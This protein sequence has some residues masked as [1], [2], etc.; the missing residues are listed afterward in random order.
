M[1]LFLSPASAAAAVCR[2]RT[3]LPTPTSA[4]LLT[5][6]LWQHEPYFP[7]LQTSMG[8]RQ[9]PQRPAAWTHLRTHNNLQESNRYN[10]TDHQL[11]LIISGMQ[12]LTVCGC[13][14]Q[15][16]MLR[17]E[18][19]WALNGTAVPTHQYRSLQWHHDLTHVSHG[20][21]EGHGC[22]HRNSWSLLL[23]LASC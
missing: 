8:L 5:G 22:L 3:C 18:S 20:R 10:H 1:C 7:S 23:S 12:S 2:H 9:I 14:R 11:S 13:W 4:W 19:K 6:A 15:D 17:R 21:M 16:R